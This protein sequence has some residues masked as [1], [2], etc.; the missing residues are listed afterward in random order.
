[1]STPKSVWIHR[2]HSQSET[3]Q[4][5]VANLTYLLELLWDAQKRLRLGAPMRWVSAHLTV[6]GP[7]VLASTRLET[8]FSEGFNPEQAGLTKEKPLLI[9]FDLRGTSPRIYATDTN[10]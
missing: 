8:L 9:Q 5:D 4:V 2:L 1:M 7:A 10:N 6:D 3:I